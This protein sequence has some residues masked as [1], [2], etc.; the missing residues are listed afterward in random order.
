MF[1]FPCSYRYWNSSSQF[2]KLHFVWES[3]G[4]KHLR[5]SI[6]FDLKIWDSQHQ[7]NATKPWSDGTSGR[8][9]MISEIREID[10]FVGKRYVRPFQ[11]LI[12]AKKRLRKHCRFFPKTLGVAVLWKNRCKKQIGHIP[13]NQHFRTW[14]LVVGSR[15][16]WMSF[17]SFKWFRPFLFR[18]RLAVGFRGLFAAPLGKPRHLGTYLHLRCEVLSQ[19]SHSAHPIKIHP[20]TRGRKDGIT[21][22]AYGSTH[23]HKSMGLAYLPTC[24]P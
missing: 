15:S 14:K 23:N 22:P 24:K 5:I 9:F 18:G 16:R 12:K 21:M 7:L 11:Q 20:P 6:C 17:V 8:V 1:R 2:F 4:P 10:F 3:A 13:W 19:K